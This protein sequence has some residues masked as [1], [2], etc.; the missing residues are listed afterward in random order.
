MLQ[1]PRPSSQPLLEETGPRAKGEQLRRGRARQFAGGCR[2]RAGS[3]TRARA[4]IIPQLPAGLHRDKLMG[5]RLLP[6]AHQ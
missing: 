5:D 6:A 3:G 2:G 1:L 4:V